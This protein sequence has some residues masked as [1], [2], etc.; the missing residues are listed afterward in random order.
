M[1]KKKHVFILDRPD[2]VLQRK[3][4]EDRPNID[5]IDAAE[6]R[7]REARAALMEHQAK[8]RSDNKYTMEAMALR[9]TNPRKLE[10]PA[11][12]YHRA[13]V[14]WCKLTVAAFE[15]VHNDAVDKVDEN[16]K[17]SE[18]QKL[19]HQANNNPN[20]EGRAAAEEKIRAVQ[21]ENAP[22]SQI[23]RTASNGRGSVLTAFNMGTGRRLQDANEDR[24]VSAND[25]LRKAA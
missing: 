5:V 12:E 11:R 3:L 13:F 4:I 10:E 21:K 2:F 14:E 24:F 20:P 19:V 16:I 22:Y 9:L 18:F 25:P 6:L 17:R 7:L 15:I 8:L 1:S 23:I